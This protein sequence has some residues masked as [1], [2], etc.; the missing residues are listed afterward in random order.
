MRRWIVLLLWLSPQSPL[1]PHPLFLRSP[2]DSSSK[3]EVTALAKKIYA[4]HRE[5]SAK[6]SNVGHGLSGQPHSDDGAPHVQYGLQVR[7]DGPGQRDGFR[8]VWDHSRS[9][10][11]CVQIV[12][13][14][15]RVLNPGATNRPIAEEQRWDCSRL[16]GPEPLVAFLIELCAMRR[17][18]D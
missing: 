12:Q 4:I 16:A 10:V 5:P 9:H 2:M 13:V 6:E 11:A 15:D 1:S 3:P 7:S 14:G 18:Q 17:R 8:L